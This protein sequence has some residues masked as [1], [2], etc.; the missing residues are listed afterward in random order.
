M[1]KE[2]LESFRL[3]LQDAGFELLTEAPGESWNGSVSVEWIDPRTN[4]SN[5]AKHKLSI[6]LPSG[7]PYHAPIVISRDDPP[8][9]SSWHLA[10][11][12]AHSLCLW[13]TEVGWQPHFTAQYLL[14]RIEDWFY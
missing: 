5:V 8:L 3:W 4:Q 6:I 9:A 10:P 12:P 11:E 7:F 14:N 1:L 2:Y 13:D